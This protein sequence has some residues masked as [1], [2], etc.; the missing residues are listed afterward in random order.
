MAR[1]FLDLTQRPPRSP[2]VRLGGYVWL[3]RL[4]DKARA[5]LAGKAGEYRYNCPID[6]RWFAFTG[7]SAEALLAEVAKEKSDG[8]LLAWITANAPI[9]RSPWEIAAWSTYMESRSPGDAE[10]HR[11]FAETIEKLAPQREDI[12]TWFDLLDLDD[13]VSIGGNA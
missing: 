13:Y 1:F 12:T 8:E 11:S 7:L 9:R 10:W 5:H 2:R 6:Q 4:L 3:P